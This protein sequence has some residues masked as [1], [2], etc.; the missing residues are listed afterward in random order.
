MNRNALG[1]LLQLQGDH[2]AARAHLDQALAIYR[3]VGTLESPDALSASCNLATTL[4]VQGRHAEAEEAALAAAQRF[5][6]A[7]LRTGFAG[8]ERATF[9]A[10]HSP[11]EVLAALLARRDQAEQAW[12]HLEANLARGLLD[13]LD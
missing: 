10:T 2:G 12:Q 8:L 1:A 13:D 11:L 7:R 9:A 6:R 5:E 4:L 3:K